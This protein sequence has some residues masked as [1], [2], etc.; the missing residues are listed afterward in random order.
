MISRATAAL[1]L[2]SLVAGC[3]VAQGTTSEPGEPTGTAGTQ[4]AGTARPRTDIEAALDCYLTTNPDYSRGRGTTQE[5]A[6]SD[7]AG[8]YPPITRTIRWQDPGAS[9]PSEG[10][11]TTWLLYGKDGGGY[12]TASVS[13]PDPGVEEWAAGVDRLC[14]AALAPPP[15]AYTDRTQD[16]LSGPDSLADPAN[17]E[18]VQA[19]ESAIVG[20]AEGDAADALRAAGWRVRV[21]ERDGVPRGSVGSASSWVNLAITD[22]TVTGFTIG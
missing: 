18:F 21:G 17:S 22:G 1:A 4:S 7:L 8:W 12:G 6:V 3:G 13:Q 14:V 2:V 5:A 9:A 16:G 20:L 11:A 10:G 15:N 19:M